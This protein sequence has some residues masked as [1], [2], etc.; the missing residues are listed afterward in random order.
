MK[1]ALLSGLMLVLCFAQ[2][3]AQERPLTTDPLTGLPLIPAT[4]PG[5]HLGN[6]PSRL[7]DSM[8]CKS[9][10]QAD[11]YSLFHTKVDAT[12]AWYG[13]H[14]PTFKKVHGYANHRSQDYFYKP[15]GTV[16]VSI[17]GQQA[18]EG[19]NADGYS[20][21]YLRFQPPLSEKAMVSM[22]T[23]KVVCQ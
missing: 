20:V 13:A 22:G 2:A 7:P 14:L 12:L 17:T 9:T 16:V 10:M 11:F 21:S 5:L 3:A 15:D 18:V 19:Q 1:T 23:G 6:A 4:D 8:F